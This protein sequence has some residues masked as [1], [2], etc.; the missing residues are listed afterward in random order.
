MH[1]P[2]DI[3]TAIFWVLGGLGLFLYGIEMMG[4]ALRKAAGTALRRGLDFLTRTRFHGLVTGTVITGLVQSSSATTVM[5]VG[6][7]SAGLLSFPQSIGLILGANI[8]TT[9]TPQIVLL[10]LDK[11]A[12]PLVGMGFLLNFL[13]RKRTVR[14]LG[15]ALMGFGM[16]FLGLMLMKLAV[17]DYGDNIRGWLGICAQGGLAGKFIAFSIATITTA[18]VQSSAATIVMLLAMAS[19]GA[20]TDIE[21][22]IPMILGA[23]IGTCITAVL[24]SLRSSKSARKAAAA[25]VLFNVVGTLITAALFRYYVR[26]I[27]MTAQTLEHQIPNCHLAIKLVNVLVFLPF[28]RHLAGLINFLMPG[29]DKLSAAPEFLCHADLHNPLQA[30]DNVRLEIHRM[31]R[32]CVDITKDAVDAF[33]ENDDLAQELVL[34][35]EE[36]VDDLY[37]GIANYVLDI[38]ALEMR[39]ELA[40]RPQELMTILSDVERIGDHAENIV[41]ISQAFKK[42]NAKLSEHAD[43]DIK[44]LIKMVGSMADDVLDLFENTDEKTVGK[45]I[46]ARE[47]L[48]EQSAEMMRHHDK[49]LEKGKCTIMASIVFTDM[50]TNLRRVANHLRNIAATLGDHPIK[51]DRA[52]I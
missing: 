31:C 50:V 33:L 37:E 23:H 47:K 13:A 28:T 4:R 5:I 40:S 38:S 25:H 39:A 12:I 9:V 16:L 7:I 10:D 17:Q 44:S 51:P 24:A 48:D 8:G 21:I 22:A 20:I 43:K 29:K 15:L 18:I 1:S 41:E 45:V 19:Q 6:F 42:K 52:E 26:F 3:I 34:K 49:R 35:Q 32:I 30:L 2:D 11:L 36:L 46:Q 14:Q 27:P